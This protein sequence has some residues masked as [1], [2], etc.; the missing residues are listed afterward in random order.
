[1]VIWC[2][3]VPFSFSRC[4]GWKI[5]WIMT[6][7]P[8]CFFTLLE[9]NRSDFGFVP[10]LRLPSQAAVNTVKTNVG[11]ELGLHSRYHT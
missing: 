10:R 3:L 8:C 2:S 4:V 9:V 5:G 7:T 6:S 1:M 11:D